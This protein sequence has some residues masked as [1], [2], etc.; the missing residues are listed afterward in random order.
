MGES[1][2]LLFHTAMLGST[3]SLIT[4]LAAY[5]Y[6]GVRATRP[7]LVDVGESPSVGWTWASRPHSFLSTR[8]RAGSNFACALSCFVPVDCVSSLV[9][10]LGTAFSLQYDSI[11]SMYRPPRGSGEANRRRQLE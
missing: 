10:S 2:T 8:W 4:L 11:S 6:N 5:V 9:A 3:Q 7:Q 1:P